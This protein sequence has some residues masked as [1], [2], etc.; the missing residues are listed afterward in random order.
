MINPSIKVKDIV[1]LVLK[2]Y[3]CKVFVS[4]ARRGK[5]KALQQYKTCLEDH[6]GMLWSYATEILNFNEG[7]TC[8][9]GVDVMLD[10]KAYFSCFY[11][12]FKA[13]KEGWLEGCRRMIG[14]DGCFLKTLCKG[15]L[16]SAVGI[17]EAAKDVMPLSEHR[18]CTR[19]IYANFRKK[20]IGVQFRSLFWQAAKA[21]YPAKFEKIMQEIK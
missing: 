16:L 6:Y 2:R 15:E 18:Q 19:H 3:K 10:G 4:Q 8:K 14:L 11:V 5:I 21:T 1:A 7:S 12:C 13:L 17:I 9:V 20:F